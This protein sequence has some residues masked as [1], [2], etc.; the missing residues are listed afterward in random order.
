MSPSLGDVKAPAGAARSV[1]VGALGELVVGDGSA[2][3]ARLGNTSYEGL[4]EKAVE[5]AFDRSS[6]Y[7][8]ARANWNAR[9]QRTP[10]NAAPRGALVF[11][12]TSTNAHVAISLGNGKVITTS[13]GGRIGIVP[14]SYFQNPL[15][16]A[17]APW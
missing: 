8:S 17:R 1:S 15:G 5:N 16:W 13:A 10:Y 11:Y 9:A 3:V 7:P 2:G 4:C 6:V 12:N 14:I